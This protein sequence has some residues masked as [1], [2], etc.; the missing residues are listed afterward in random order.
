MWT[1]KYRLSWGHHDNNGTSSCGGARPLLNG[2]EIVPRASVAQLMPVL[3]V[4]RLLVPNVIAGPGQPVWGSKTIAGQSTHESDHHELW[5]KQQQQQQ[6]PPP[7]HRPSSSRT[8]TSSALNHFPHRF[9][10]T[11]GP[12]SSSTAQAGSA[13]LRWKSSQCTAP[14]SYRQVYRKKTCYVTIIRREQRRVT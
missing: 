9:H 10:W 13:L 6:Q 7:Y 4:V 8:T 1:E 3:L 11:M 12:D 2:R 14:S 5:S